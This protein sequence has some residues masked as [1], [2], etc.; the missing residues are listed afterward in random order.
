MA[1]PLISPASSMYTV[2]QPPAVEPPRVENFRARM[3]S[4]SEMIDNAVRPETASFEQT[5]LRAFDAMNAQQMQPA[6]LAEQMIVEPDS[7]DPHDITIAMS[8]ANL[9]IRLAQTVI[10]RVVRGWTEITN[11]R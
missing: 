5:L 3:E 9:S 4:S 8:Q 10:D 2:V 6:K 7:V 1:F 11:V